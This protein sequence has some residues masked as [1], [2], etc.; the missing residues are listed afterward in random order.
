MTKDEATTL[1]QALAFDRADISDLL[2]ASAGTNASGET[3]HRPYATAA[4]L[5]IT[6]KN[7]QR[8]LEARGAV[9]EHPRQ[10]IDGLLGMQVP[11]DAGLTIADEWTVEALRRAAGGGEA[12]VVF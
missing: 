12:T 7:T 1:V 8:L 5:W 4:F 2:D 6:A 11:W 3:V 9:F 10:M